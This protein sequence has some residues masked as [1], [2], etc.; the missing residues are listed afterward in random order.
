MLLMMPIG[1]ANPL[2]MLLMM[3]IGRA[4]LEQ[5]VLICRPSADRSA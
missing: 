1:R 4:N 5:Q 3:L 2:T